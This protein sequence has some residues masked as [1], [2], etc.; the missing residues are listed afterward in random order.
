[1]ISVPFYYLPTHNYM[2]H[3]QFDHIVR[4]IALWATF[5]SLFKKLFCQIF[6]ILGNFCKGVEIFHFP[7]E[8]IFGQLL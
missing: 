4:F 2:S 3:R 7:S 5:Q 1:M 6:H 8:I